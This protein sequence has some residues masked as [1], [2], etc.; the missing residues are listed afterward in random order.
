[1]KNFSWTTFNRQIAIKAKLEI[2]YDAWAKPSEIE[3]WF[4]KSCDYLNDNKILID[5]ADRCR[6]NYSYQWSWFLYDALEDGRITEA[7]GK[8]HIQF[9]FIGECLVDVKL[10]QQGE[11]VIVNVRQHNI[12]EDENSKINIRLDCDSGW[13]FYLVNL[14]SFYEHGIDLRNKDTSL[15]G[16]IN[17]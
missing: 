1:M 15:K 8:D 5:K 3:K 13:S 14:K 12:P 16:M 7:N 9:T 10:T 11:Y 6:K 4:L 17:N 2:L